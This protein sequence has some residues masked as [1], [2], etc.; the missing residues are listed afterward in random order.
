MIIDI[1][2]DITQYIQITLHL[3]CFQQSNTESSEDSFE[4]DALGPSIQLCRGRGR[5]H[6]ESIRGRRRVRGILHQQRGV[7]G[8]GTTHGRG[9]R[10]G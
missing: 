6:G 10:R 8:L 2:H 3:F 1:N 9:V 4:D 5:G 7:R